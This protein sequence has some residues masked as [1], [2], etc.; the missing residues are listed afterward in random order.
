MAKILESVLQLNSVYGSD[1]PFSEAAEGCSEDL[2]L[3]RRGLLP[4]FFVEA[5]EARYLCEPKRAGEMTDEVVQ[6]KAK[7]ATLWCQHA[8]SVSDKTLAL[9]SNSA[10]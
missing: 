1:R 5:T 7:A 10:R 9:R 2:L 3:P 6:L 4:D 8:T